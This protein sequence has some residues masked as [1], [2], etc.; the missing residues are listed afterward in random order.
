MCGIFTWDSDDF[1][2]VG[3]TGRE[4]GGL[5][6]TV[7]NNVNNTLTNFP[8]YPTHSANVVEVNGIITVPS[9]GALGMGSPSKMIA[10]MTARFRC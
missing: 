7:A 8:T 2:H 9:L 3:G 1:D 5:R 4:G 10:K 6:E